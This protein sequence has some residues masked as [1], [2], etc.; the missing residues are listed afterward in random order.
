LKGWSAHINSILPDILDPL[1][2]AYRP[3][4]SI[5]YTI[6]ITLHTA[7]SHLDKM[8]NYVIML[9]IDYSSVFHTIM[10]MKLITKL[11]TLGLNTSF[12]NWIL[13]FLTG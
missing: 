4:R 2:L 6:S 5:D 1:Q 12:C 11:K 7:L 8:N 3:N 9:F 10:H 13:Y